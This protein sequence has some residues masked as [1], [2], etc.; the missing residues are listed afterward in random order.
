MERFGFC[1]FVLIVEHSAEIVLN[2]HQIRVV[3]ALAE[4]F[5]SLRQYLSGYGLVFVAG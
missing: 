2:S 4:E 3:V 1:T 5:L